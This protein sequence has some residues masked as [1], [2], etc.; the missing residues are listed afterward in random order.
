[1]NNADLLY[2]TYN[3]FMVGDGGMD[4]LDTDAWI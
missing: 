1:M 2:D 4:W 3:I